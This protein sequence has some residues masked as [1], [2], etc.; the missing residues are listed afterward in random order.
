MFHQQVRTASDVC[1]NVGLGAVKGET[2]PFYPSLNGCWVTRLSVHALYY[3]LS[4]EISVGF[5]RNKDKC[6]GY[7]VRHSTI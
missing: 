4:I 3:L 6:Y 1:P 2:C 5:N 7:C